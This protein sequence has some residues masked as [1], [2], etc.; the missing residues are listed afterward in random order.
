VALGAPSSYLQVS[1][2][3]R[4]LCLLPPLGA[5][6]GF[7]PADELLVRPELWEPAG[8]WPPCGALASFGGLHGGASR[9][10]IHALLLLPP[11]PGMP[12]CLHEQRTRGLGAT[13]AVCHE[14]VAGA[15][16]RRESADFRVVMGA[17]GGGQPFSHHPRAGRKE[18]HKVSDGQPATG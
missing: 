16:G 14:D 15:P 13:A 8:A 11:E 1:R 4:T 17:Q 3:E 6:E 18:R 9:R 2:Q 10:K 7:E 12:A 5:Q